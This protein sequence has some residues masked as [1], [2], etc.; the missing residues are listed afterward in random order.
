VH[1][2]SANT[3]TR[4]KPRV[5]YRHRFF[6]FCPFSWPHVIFYLFVCLSIYHGKMRSTMSH[7]FEQGIYTQGWKNNERTTPPQPCVTKRRIC[8]NSLGENVKRVK[9]TYSLVHNP[10]ANTNTRTRPRVVYR[11]RLFGS[12]PFCWPRVIF[13]LFVYLSITE[14]WDLRWAMN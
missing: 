2:P 13:Y 10:S 4:T 5:V 1:N 3:N 14:R 7:K 12:C 8:G 11:H 6:G 9:W